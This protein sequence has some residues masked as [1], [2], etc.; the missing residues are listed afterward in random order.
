V[1]RQTRAPQE[2][3]GSSRVTCRH[4]KAAGRVRLAVLALLSASLITA[5]DA[6]AQDP[7]TLAPDVAPSSSFPKQSLVGP[8]RN[9]D[10][11]QPLYLQ[12][13]ELIYDN[14]GNRVI[15]RGNV[16]IYYNNYILTA[17][18][19]IYDQSA[20]TLTAVGNVVLKEPNGNIVRSDRYTLTD[21][22]RDGFVSQLSIV[23]S[24]DT[25]I[26]AESAQRRAGNTTVFR[27]GR[28]TP[29]KS[30]G[31]MPPLWCLSAATVIHDQAAATITYQDAQ[32]ELFGVPILYTPY[33]EHADP[34]VKRKSGF[35]MP[36][37]SVSDT[38]GYST[39]IPYY[40]ALAPNYDFTFYPMYTS[41]QG[42]LWQGEWRHRTED[43]QYFIRGAGIDQDADDLPSAI[44]NRDE[45]D[46]WRGSLETKGLFN[47]GSWWKA[48][49]D[50]TLESDDTFRRFYKLDNMLLT[51]R[52][53]KVFLQGIGDRNY[54]GAELY[55]FGGLMFDTEGFGQS[56]SYAYPI[57]DYNYVFADPILGGELTWNTNALSFTDNQDPSTIPGLGS[58]QMNRVVTE[59]NWRRR[60]TD[61]LGI[62]YTPFGQLRGDLYQINNYVDPVTMD[63][64]SETSMARGLAAGGVT[65][66]Y[67]WVA[68]TAGG[69]HVIEPIGQIIARQKS[70]RQDNLPNEDAQ[71]LVFDDTNLFEL[72]KFSGYDRVETGTRANVG[73]QYTFQ[74]NNGPY[75]RILA[76]ESFHLA[77]DNAYA[78]PGV[79]S[80]GNPTFTPFSGLQKD[81]S[82][83]V[84]GAYLA[85]WSFIQLISQSR[86]DQ[87]DF[88]LARQDAGG[89]VSLGP[90]SLSAIYAYLNTDPTNDIDTAQ[91][92][93]Y[94]S[95]GIRLTDHWS[96]A[97]AMRYDIDD[98]ELASDMFSVRYGDEC[99]VLTATYTDNYYS[100]PDLVDGQTLMLRFELK[101]LGEFG[102]STDALS[103]NFSEQQ[104]G[105]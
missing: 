27:N 29:C 46:G 34:S 13:D 41:R 61:P 65:V 93:V 100:N 36:Q 44:Q 96:I 85:P 97:A 56:R 88:T 18:E 90:V 38:L 105:G 99:F 102:Y 104:S 84:L 70:V 16:E 26:A 59:V 9:I 32:F 98:D 30:D 52:V 64:V 15:A 17:D 92:D 77:G 21:D 7:S 3:C 79:D 42:V 72:T 75:A 14:G 8:S 55:H 86:F 62:T 51:D 22:F 12:G 80:D 60:L 95:L 2:G 69:S 57:I 66:A 103:Y 25:R 37:P 87:S 20:N 67:P 31:G 82:D 91:E 101:H 40:F 63:V 48:G 1:M 35:L 89:S 23:A 45:Y 78:D 50:V 5:H 74:A 58:A 81:R 4:R 39:T 68:N 10:R 28:F 71:S 43:G 6:R 33:F 19:V 11:S 24:D 83:Y 54:F 49:W 73:V 94:A 76:G 53:N 47:I